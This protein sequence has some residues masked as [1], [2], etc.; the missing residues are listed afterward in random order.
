MRGRWARLLLLKLKMGRRKQFIQRQLGAKQF[1][2]AYRGF[3]A[4]QSLRIIIQIHRFKEKA[5]ECAVRT[6]QGQLR[7]MLA[8]KRVRERQRDLVEAEALRQRGAVKIQNMFRNH[9]AVNVLTN[10]R[11]L[12]FML[13]THAAISVQRV[14]RG[15]L[16]RQRARL[17]GHLLTEVAL[18]I[19]R[20]FRGRG[21]RLIY[22]GRLAAREILRAR[23][24]E[25]AVVVQSAWRSSVARSVAQL[26]I[27]L[28]VM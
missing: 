17:H 22:R 1:Q 16:G 18:D 24:N 12:R 14:F 3:A 27:A 13:E 10:L 28:D 5:R 20:V 9:V 2:R 26:L 19:Q 15:W 8:R 7:I 6:L 11:R 4:R 21:G 25:A 23:K